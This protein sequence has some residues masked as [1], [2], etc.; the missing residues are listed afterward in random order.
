MVKVCQLQELRDFDNLSRMSNDKSL[1]LHLH[2]KDTLLDNVTKVMACMSCAH[3]S[4][5]VFFTEGHSKAQF[6]LTFV[7][8]V[9]TF[10]IRTHSAEP[11]LRFVPVDHDSSM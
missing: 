1:V 4:A 8:E 10:S 9:L 5:D 11:K 7:F 6:Y 2:W 3:V